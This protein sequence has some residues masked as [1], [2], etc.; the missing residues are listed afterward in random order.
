LYYIERLR[1]KLS[2][3]ALV[4]GQVLHQSF[5]HL[6]NRLGTP[7]EFFL[8]VWDELKGYDI[9]YKPTESW[10]SSRPLVEG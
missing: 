3:A 6:F 10:R 8:G 9:A 7:M 2:P 5:A 4:F 1:L